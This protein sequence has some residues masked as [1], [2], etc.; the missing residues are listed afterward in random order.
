ML[1]STSFRAAARAALVILPVLAPTSTTGFAAA[2]FF[3]FGV[4]FFLPPAL[5][6]LFLCCLD[7][8]CRWCCGG[9]GR[10]RSTLALVCGANRRVRGGREEGAQGRRQNNVKRGQ[11]ARTRSWD[12]D[13]QSPSRDC[14]VRTK[15]RR[16]KQTYQTSDRF[17]LRGSHLADR[18]R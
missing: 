10:V 4:A 14:H 3:F 9:G 7:Y 18:Y 8:G 15:N 5:G 6:I 17:I 1:C 11:E 12:A 16:P 2:F 13:I